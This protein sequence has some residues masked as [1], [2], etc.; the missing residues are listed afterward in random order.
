LDRHRQKNN[1]QKYN[2]LHQFRLDAVRFCLRN[3]VAADLHAL[4]ACAARRLLD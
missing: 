2:S 3:P 4:F 1:R